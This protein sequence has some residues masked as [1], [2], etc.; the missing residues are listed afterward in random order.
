MN[1]LMILKQI[2]E[3]AA[4]RPHFLF[5]M[6]GFSSSNFFLTAQLLV[7]EIVKL[8]GVGLVV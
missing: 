6:L 4:R 1:D 3:F 8:A 2:G 5:R 7:A